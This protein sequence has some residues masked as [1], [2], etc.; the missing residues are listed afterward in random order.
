MSGCHE[1]VFAAHRLNLVLSAYLSG[2]ADAKR[3]IKLYNSL[4]TFLNVANNKEV[5]EEEQLRLFPED[6]V[7][8]IGQLTEVRWSCKFEVIDTIIS[9]ITKRKSRI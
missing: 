1:G 2:S 6:P 9:C 7:K 5:F 8:S 3:V 4:H